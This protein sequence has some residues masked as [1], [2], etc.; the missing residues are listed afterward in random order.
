MSI[1]NILIQFCNHT[2]HPPT[3]DKECTRQVNLPT[4]KYRRQTKI[5]GV[6]NLVTDKYD[7]QIAPELQLAYSTCT[8]IR[9]VCC[10][11]NVSS[12]WKASI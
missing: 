11:I 9:N 6:Y 7:V 3:N 1:L 4:Y 5:I 12:I 10:K 2:S 8:L